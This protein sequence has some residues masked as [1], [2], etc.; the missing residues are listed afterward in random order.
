MD[1]TQPRPFI[2]NEMGL[3]SLYVYSVFLRKR[4][5]SLL[6][7]EPCANL[8]KAIVAILDLVDSVLHSG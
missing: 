5:L 1:I 4:L 7:L 2:T 6:V 3:R 8:V